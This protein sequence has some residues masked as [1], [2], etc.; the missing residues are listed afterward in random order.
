MSVNLLNARFL[1]LSFCKSVCLIFIAILWEKSDLSWITEK[2]FLTYNKGPLQEFSKIFYFDWNNIQI[3]VWIVKDKK[4]A[5]RWSELNKSCALE[6]E[7]WLMKE[8]MSMATVDLL[9]EW[10]LYDTRNPGQ[11]RD[12]LANRQ[13]VPVGD[14]QARGHGWERRREH[15]GVVSYHILLKLGGLMFLFSILYFEQFQTYRKV[16]RLVQP[17]NHLLFT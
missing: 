5:H 7:C 13:L 10:F 14:M 1:A 9:C 15:P 8:D 12:N 11:W 3:L 16:E 17:N 4:K 6:N 2:Q